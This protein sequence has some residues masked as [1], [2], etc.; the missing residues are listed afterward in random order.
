MEI[1]RSMLQAVVLVA[2]LLAG[3]GAQALQALTVEA[4]Q[5]VAQGRPFSVR[6]VSPVHVDRVEVTWLGQTLSVTLAEQTGSGDYATHVLLG[7]DVAGPAGSTVLD[8]R[9]HKHGLTL[10]REIPVEVVEQHFP[11]QHLTLPQGMVT[12]DRAALKRHAREKEQVEKALGKGVSERLWSLPLHRP[13]QGDVS[14]V[15]GLKRVLNGEPRT[16]HRGTDFRGPAGSPVRAASPGKVLLTAE[17]YF[18]GKSVYLDH[19]QGVVSMYFHL[20]AIDVAE[21]E[22][23][24]Q[25]Q[26]IG[27]IGQTGRATGP[28][29]H[30][31]LSILGQLVD[32]SGLFD[33]QV[34]FDTLPGVSHDDQG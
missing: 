8:V 5:R 33:P 28:H 3:S 10:D 24:R 22:S 7:T 19:G 26:V 30:F 29:L 31:G 25:G 11:E 2:V 21:G 6:V 34:T 27:R 20:S 4:P 23:V 17:H 14:S 9:V 12:P 16:P 15:Y 32:P 1:L 13:V 18:A